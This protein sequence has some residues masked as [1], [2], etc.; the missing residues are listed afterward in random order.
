MQNMLQ[1]VKL[2]IPPIKTST[3]SEGAVAEIAHK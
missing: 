2:A 3:K 1:R